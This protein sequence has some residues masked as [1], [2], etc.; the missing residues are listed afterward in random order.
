MRAV[1]TVIRQMRIHAL[2][3]F[4]I[5]IFGFLEHNATRSESQM[6]G[7]YTLGSDSVP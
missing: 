5:V 6:D 4:D 2:K 7:L 1:Q 3:G